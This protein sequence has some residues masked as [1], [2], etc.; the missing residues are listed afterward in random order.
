IWAGL[1]WGLSPL[2]LVPIAFGHTAYF[3]A[4]SLIPPMLLAVAAAARAPTRPGSIGAGLALAGLAGLQALTGHPQ[5]V[6]YA[7]AMCVAFAIERA[8]RTRRPA[9]A[10][11]ALVAL[12]WGAAIAMAVWL[13]ALRYGAHS[14]RGGG[15]SLELVRSMSIGWQELLA[16]AFP[17]LA[18]SSGATY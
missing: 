11:T 16:L 13:P 10:V 18:G 6:A 17:A 15:V 3:V 12:A 2:L 9:V 5:E 7:G 1:A 14:N 8:V 4:A